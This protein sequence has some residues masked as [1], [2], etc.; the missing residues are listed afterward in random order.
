[1]D[2]KPDPDRNVRSDTAS[3]PTPAPSTRAQAIHDSTEVPRVSGSVAS[4]SARESPRRALPCNVLVNTGSAY[5]I[6][7]AIHDI[8][9]VG[10][11]V[12]LDSTG[13]VLGDLV[14]VVLEFSDPPRTID[15]QLSAEVVRID[16]AGVGLRF[17]DYSDQ[18]YTD[19]VNLLYTR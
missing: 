10:V 18:T 3:G 13:L 14:D 11:F 2:R 17:C 6:A 7:H 15:I 1:M 16:R 9:L 4:H 8:S 12:E 5:L 19:L